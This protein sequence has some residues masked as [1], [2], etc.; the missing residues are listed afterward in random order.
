[1]TCTRSA[2]LAAGTALALAP[3]AAG[4]QAWIG[5]VVGN[6][7]AQQRAAEQEHACMTGKAMPEKEIVEAR[8]PAIETMRGYFADARTGAPVARYFH[9]EKAAVAELDRRVDPFARGG[10]ALEAEPVGFVRAGDG[11]TALGQWRV[12]DG[13]GAPAGTYT[14]SFTRK[15]GVWRLSWLTLT[16]P[17]RF[18]E[19]VVQYC[20]AAGDV[21]PFRLAEARQ[22][23]AY[24]ERR[25]EKVGRKAQEASHAA[26]AAE[27]KAS[28][29]RR[30]G[31]AREEAERTKARA[32]QLAAELDKARGAADKARETEL[33][34]VAES[35]AA[36]ALRNGAAP[37]GAKTGD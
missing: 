1:M 16:K 2:A 10:L 13:G 33:A 4:A 34:V 28:A 25:V 19:P 8:V 14:G 21:L 36:E 7:V 26:A 37:T 32:A 29:S 6:M 27:A 20:H 30:G 23:R 5:A 24:A 22:I 17:D 18:V 9:A 15:L 35:K 11:R 3:A 12:R 31:S